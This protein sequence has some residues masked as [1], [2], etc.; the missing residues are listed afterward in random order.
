MRR[1]CTD[2]EDFRLALV[3]QAWAL[4]GRGHQESHIVD[5]FTRAVLKPR[6]EALQ[7]SNRKEGTKNVVRLVTTYDQNINV[8]KA[9]KRVRKEKEALENTTSGTHLKEVEIQLAFRNA[10]NLRRLLIN[11]EPRD[12][13]SNPERFEGFSRCTGK[14]AF[15]KDVEDEAKIK[16]IPEVFFEKFAKKIQVESCCRISRFPQQ[17]VALKTWFIFPA[18]SPVVFSTW[19]KQVTR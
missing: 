3:D 19:A 11:K 8:V 5:G 7:R 10:L 6:A 1:L 2:D 4:L 12:P 13:V 16:K 18:V 15:C 9:F 17:I 14:C